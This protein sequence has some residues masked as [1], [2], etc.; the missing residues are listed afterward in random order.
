MIQRGERAG[1]ALE[2]LQ[3]LRVAGDVVGQYLE[4]DVASELRVVG[5]IDL[6]HA[7][8]T[9]RGKDFVGTQADSRR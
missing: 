3:A 6:A 7:P 2:A 4:G 8:G 1:F 5:A 9:E